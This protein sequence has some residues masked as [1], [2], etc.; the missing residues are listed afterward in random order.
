VRWLNSQ[1]HNMSRP[2]LSIYLKKTVRTL[3]RHPKVKE[4]IS[5]IRY[6]PSWKEYLD[7]ARNSVTDQMPWI[8]FSAI[9]F[10]KKI[11][12][13]EMKVF[14]YGSGGS[15]LYWASRVSQV[16][17]VEHDRS[18]YEKMKSVLAGRQDK[19][20]DLFL[21]EAEP[22]SDSTPK[23]IE[24]P[25]D[26]FSADEQYK[27]KNFRKYVQSIDRYPDFH[28]DIIAID[29][30]ARPSCIQHS[31]SKIR[32]GGYLIIDNTEREYY[33]ASFNFRKTA[34]KRWDFEGPVPYI[35]HFSQTTI[36]QKNK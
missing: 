35:M 28:F 15:T 20:V 27:G 30:R 17:S 36:I 8:S 5:I 7:P 26:Y 34:W 16:V 6:Y 33:L 3:W 29:G 12:S 21:V 32:P 9:D 19:N 31:I 4:L 22:D 10:I 23:N 14:E 11:V 1:I 25:A 24:N 13:Q 2:R 18:W